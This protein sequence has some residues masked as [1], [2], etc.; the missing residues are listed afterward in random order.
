MANE[1]ALC[2]VEVEGIF[3]REVELAGGQLAD[4]FSDGTLLLLRAVTP[5][6]G[7]VQRGDRVQGGVAL[8]S[9]CEHVYVHPYVFRQVCTNG[10]IRAQAIETA[11]IDLL[12]VPYGRDVAE[13]LREAVVRC[14]GRDV[15]SQSVSEMRSAL[16]READIALHVLPWL[17]QHQ[18]ALPARLARQIARRFVQS[19][20]RSHYGL[21]NA[22]TSV[23]RDTT[24]AR[25]RWRLEELGGGVPLDALD[26]PPSR[27]ERGARQLQTV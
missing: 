1:P 2:A 23:A 12:E 22:V 11:H 20:D 24:D 10:A 5:R 19:R 26:V 15:L 16:E 3:T 7:E 27:P 25:T 4:R 9:D 14:L 6:A 13:E 18:A 21:M 8:R 17:S